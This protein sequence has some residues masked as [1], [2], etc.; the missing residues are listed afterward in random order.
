MLLNF[1][2]AALMFVTAA[3]LPAAP[4]D[5]ATAAAPHLALVEPAASP[6]SPLPRPAFHEMAPAQVA[7]SD[8]GVFNSVAISAAR[9]PAA[10]RWQELRRTDFSAFFGPD[11]ATAGFAGCDSR[12]L[13]RLRNVRE[14]AAGL[15][16]RERL[17]IVN[18]GVNA[19]MAYRSDKSVWG[20]GDYWATPAEMAR[21]GAGDCEDYAIAKYWLLRSLG[22]NEEN[23]QLVLLQ[24]TRRQLFHAVLI[25]HTS[26]GRFVLDNVGNRLQDDS[27]YSQYQPI[28]SFAGTRSYVHGFA[29]G[30]ST[31]TA[32]PTDLSAVVPG[33]GI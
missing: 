30:R 14:T 12:F 29:G 31:K 16:G 2:A 27:A 26:A 28:M 25:V 32:M 23:L 8:L 7:T 24:D 33:S 1:A 15:G 20:V 13:T 9:T 5:I 18:R 4:L 21:Q 19:A 11:C 22:M 17:D 6:V 3:A 10:R